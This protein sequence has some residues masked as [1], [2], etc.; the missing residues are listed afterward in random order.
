MKGGKEVKKKLI[1]IQ[2]EISDC[3][4]CSLLS[5]IRYYG[6]NA[7]LE[8]IRSLSLTT[9]YGVTALN[10]I[11]CAKKYGFDA[12]G[13]KVVDFNDLSLPFIA[14]FNINESLSHFV[15]VY[16]I[17]EDN[18]TIMD[19]AKGKRV[20]S[21]T[22]FNE[23]FTGNIIEL[24]PKNI[25]VE[26]IGDNRLM[27]YITKVHLEHKKRILIL[28]SMIIFIII[29][30]V[31]NSLYINLMLTV[32]KKILLFV[33]F[34]LIVLF[35]GVLDKKVNISKSKL[36][37]SVSKKLLPNFFEHILF[38]PLN[39]IHLKDSGEII[40]R[41]E[42]FEEIKN[43]TFEFII[44]FIINSV[45]IIILL[46]LLCFIHAFFLFLTLFL[47]V[48]YLLYVTLSCRNIKER[49]DDLLSSSTEYRSTIVD[50]IS[51]ITSINHA[52]AEDYALNRVKTSLDIYL[53]NNQ[54]YERYICK[55]SMIKGKIIG[56]FELI[57]N[58]ILLSD[59]FK[60][61]ITLETII[62]INNLIML[63]LSSIENIANLIP[64]LI[65]YK[66]I[67]T[68]V[69][70]F[71]DLKEDNFEGETFINGS[72]EFS[73]VSFSYN[74]LTQI[75]DNL[76]FKID[77][78]EKV[79]IKGTSGKGKSTI[80]KL[81]NKEYDNYSGTISI[82]G[83]EIQSVSTKSLRENISYSCQTEKI[84][85]GT[86]KE[87]IFMGK[88]ADEDKFNKIIK[89]C[90]LDRIVKNRPFKY[91]TFLYGGGEELSGGERQLII[92]A[93]TLMLDKKIIIL[94]ETLSEVNDMLEDRILR[95]IFTYYKDNTVIYISHKNK[96]KYFKRVIN[97]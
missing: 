20:I 40:K 97:V 10:L 90:E 67:I 89:I 80:C 79:I 70:E 26:H 68:R 58:T 5:I 34:I 35:R 96:K 1:V 36:S 15:V 23:L 62:L 77:R 85:T 84:F 4:A 91:D 73:N 92:L 16:K 81:I 6:G 64:N 78:G 48:I 33:L 47:I 45:L 71:Y 21:T 75:I 94:D 59:Y 69:N 72:I 28:L 13:K 8:N 54:K 32:N 55:T 87:N 65:Y 63:V 42:E 3:G 24:Y 41:M 61:N 95:K 25:S 44:T 14:H 29:L 53:Q 7:N 82:G 22:E 37:I 46:M 30:T 88:V 74:K 66:G 12:I 93:R 43:I 60:G 56:L 27:K 38:L 57:C 50:N 39:Y 76:S 19:P 2:E 86:I 17:E 9:H 51:G 52:H 11:E 83:K 18:V 31:L 49:I